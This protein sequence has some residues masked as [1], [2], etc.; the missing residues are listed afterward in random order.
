MFWWL[1]QISS[2]ALMTFLG[3][4][5]CQW[6]ELK[7]MAFGGKGKPTTN[8]PALARGEE[9]GLINAEGPGAVEMAAMASKNG[10]LSG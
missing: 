10:P 8:G 4:W 1:L 3:V 2:A 7:P 9:A 6:R 5:A